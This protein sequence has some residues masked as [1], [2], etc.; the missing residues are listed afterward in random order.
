[1]GKKVSGKGYY[2]STF[3]WDGKADGAYLDFGNMIQ[4][5][6]VYIN[7]MKT[8]DLNMNNPVLDISK[9]LKTCSCSFRSI[10]EQ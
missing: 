4:S 7:G 5:M 9:Y 8:S 2:S 1:M 6:Q 3:N 10:H